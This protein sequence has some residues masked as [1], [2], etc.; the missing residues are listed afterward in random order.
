M[1]KTRFDSFSVICRYNQSNKSQ[2]TRIINC[3]R[4]DLNPCVRLYNIKYFIVRNIIL[5]ILTLYLYLITTFTTC[6]IT[7]WTTGIDTA[8]D[9]VTWKAGTFFSTP[10]TKIRHWTYIIAVSAIITRRTCYKISLSL[11]NMD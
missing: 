9:M 4:S 1:L 3:R 10:K 11:N 8:V 2:N 7:C 5:I 6:W